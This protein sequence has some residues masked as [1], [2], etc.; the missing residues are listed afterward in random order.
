MSAA[1]ME[2]EVL[3]GVVLMSVSPSSCEFDCSGPSQRREGTSTQQ[4]SPSK[5]RNCWP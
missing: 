2:T 4:S 5:E 3:T 1:D